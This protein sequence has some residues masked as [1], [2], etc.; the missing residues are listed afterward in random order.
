MVGTGDVRN[1]GGPGGCEEQWWARGKYYQLRSGSGRGLVRSGGSGQGLVRSGD[2]ALLFLFR[3]DFALSLRST[4]LLLF[5]DFGNRIEGT[6]HRVEQETWCAMAFKRDGIG[7][8]LA[9][10]T[11]EALEL[12]EWDS[13]CSSRHGRGIVI[14]STASALETAAQWL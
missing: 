10:E 2:G 14:A 3:L 4:I 7:I 12:N 1:N 9:S 6:G 5:E 13:R 8:A 11:R